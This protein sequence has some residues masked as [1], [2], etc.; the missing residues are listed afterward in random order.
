MD[1]LKRIG[2]SIVEL[3]RNFIRGIGFFFIDVFEM[4]IR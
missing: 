1:C 2:C 4:G 3:R